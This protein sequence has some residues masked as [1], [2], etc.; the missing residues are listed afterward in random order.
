MSDKGFFSSI[1]GLF[2]SLFVPAP[3]Q[4]A[5]ATAVVSTAVKEEV[6]EVIQEVVEAEAPST[7]TGVARYIENIAGKANTTTGVVEAEAPST[8]TGVARYIEN[9]ASKAST[10]TGVER[11]IRNN[12]TSNHAW[13]QSHIMTGVERYIQHKASN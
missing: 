7:M 1:C 6:T 5:E 13:L 3:Q 8:M 2:N 9:I 12:M 10:I 11:Y 4:Q